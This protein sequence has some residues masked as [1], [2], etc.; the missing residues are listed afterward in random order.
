[1]ASTSD[2]S[3]IKDLK[4]FDLLLEQFRGQQGE[5]PTAS[6]YLVQASTEYNRTRRANLIRIA[7][8][9][10]KHADILGSIL[11]QISKGVS[12]PLSTRIDRNEFK[13]FLSF[14]GISTHKFS[15]GLSQL[16]LAPNSRQPI[17]SNQLSNNPKKYLTA[18]IDTETKQ[19]IAYQRL[20][21]LTDDANFI[22]ALNYIQ[23]RQIQHRNDFIEMLRS[24]AG[25][26]RSGGSDS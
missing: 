15:A 9:K 6:A 23:A 14:N 13:E 7:K 3:F 19:I 25:K 2:G 26:D 21:E 17:D 18:N 24:L 16:R 4:F 11:L 20:V 22:S 12:G 8:T 5:L 10:I 1:M